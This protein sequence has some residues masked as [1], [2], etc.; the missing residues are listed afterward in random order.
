MD[1]LGGAII[2]DQKFPIREGLGENGFHGLLQEARAIVGRDDDRDSGHG[3]TS[4]DAAGVGPPET[5]FYL[6][7]AVAS[8]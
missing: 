6:F 2:D 8:P 7:Q 1:V 3:I 5:P 4:T